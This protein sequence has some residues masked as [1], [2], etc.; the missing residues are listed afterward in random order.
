MRNKNVF[1]LSTILISLIASSNVVPESTANFSGRGKSIVSLSGKGE[2]R[3]SAS[4]KENRIFHEGDGES[5]IS[6]RYAMIGTEGTGVQAS[7]DASGS[8]MTFLS[9]LSPSEARVASKADK[10]S[11]KSWFLSGT[12]DLLHPSGADQTISSMEGEVS[13]GTFGAVLDSKAQ[14]LIT[15]A[16]SAFLATT[17]THR[18]A[19]RSPPELFAASVAE[20]RAGNRT[21]TSEGAAYGNATI[22][23]LA[24]PELGS[25]TM[26]FGDHSAVSDAAT[27]FGKLEAKQELQISTPKP[28][29]RAKF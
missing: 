6:S 7:L 14:G 9:R 12:Q 19:T 10:L 20:E 13:R 18:N 15:G 16:D 8:K 3:I 27:N 26:A 2:F 28:L 22:Q 17:L 29:P 24:T 1:L 25:K 4:G 23:A 21:W 11:T 5:S